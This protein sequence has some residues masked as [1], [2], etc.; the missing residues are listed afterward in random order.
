MLD[1]DCTATTSP[2]RILFV[3]DSRLMRFAGKRFLGSDYDV[4]IAENGQEAWEH[5]QN[6]E[7]IRVVF[8][9]LIMPEVDGH[10]LIQRARNSDDARVRDLPILVI[11]GTDEEEDRRRA[12]RDGATDLIPKPFSH[13]DLTEPARLH[14]RRLP[15]LPERNGHDK[16][17]SNVE[18]KP[19]QCVARID[20]ALSFHRRHHLEMA[21]IHVRLDNHD[22]IEQELGRSWA[23]SALRHV[24][25]TLAREV[26]KEDTV[27]RSGENTFSIILMATHPAGARVLS[28]RLRRHLC[29]DEVQ[30][31]GRHLQLAVSFSV[32]ALGDHLEQPAESVLRAGLDRLNV[33]ANVTRL[34]DRRGCVL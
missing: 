18:D 33:P 25:R 4:I 28:D 2:P 31:P 3:D 26:R 20:Q 32:Q 7:N 23:D 16:L 11:T 29:A 27:C 19:G 6:D 22:D 24:G 15:P 30:F 17:P 21:L 12:L 9:D 5:I 13:T 34:S 10:E 8:T 1:S 14:T